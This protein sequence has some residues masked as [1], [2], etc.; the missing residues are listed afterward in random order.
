[1]CKIKRKRILFDE[2]VD[3]LVKWQQAKGLSTEQA[4]CNLSGVKLMKLLYFTCLISVKTEGEVSFIKDT[5]FESF[6]G[7]MPYPK[8]PVEV[9][10]YNNRENLFRYTYENGLMKSNENGSEKF[11]SALDYELD[12]DK[13]AYDKDE[14][15]YFKQQLRLLDLSLSE[16]FSINV[17]PFSDV[18]RLVEISH[19]SPLWNSAQIKNGVM[20]VTNISYVNYDYDMVIPSLQ[21][22][23]SNN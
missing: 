22:M 13:N 12:K 2:F 5:L 20:E 23:F 8:G 15:A 1:M 7:F 16:L 9:D 21:Q 10:A 6:D 3:R 14:N 17:T 11:D 19:L 18:D 4:L